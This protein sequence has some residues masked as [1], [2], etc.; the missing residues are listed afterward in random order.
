MSLPRDTDLLPPD[1]RGYE[2][3]AEG[4]INLTQFKPQGPVGAAFLADRDSMIRGIRGPFGSGKTN[5]AFYDCYQWAAASP[6]T[7]RRTSPESGFKPIRMFGALSIRDTY[8]NLET[9]IKSWHAW[10]TR[11]DGDWTGGSGDRPAKHAIAYDLPD[12]TVLEFVHE[13][14]AIGDRTIE[15][16]MLG[17]EFNWIFAN[18]LTTLGID[19]LTYAAGRVGRYPSAKHFEHPDPAVR[20]ARVEQRPAKIIADFNAPEIGTE[21]Y[22]YWEE[23][24][25]ENAKLYVQ[26]G[27]RHP[28]AENL[29]NLPKDYYKN[30]IALNIHKP[31]WIKRFIDNEYGFSRTG[32]PVFMDEFNDERHVPQNDIGI[33][34]LP[35]YIGLD[36][37][38]GLQPAATIKQWSPQG[39]IDLVLS[40][41]LGR[42]GPARFA[43][44]L[45]ALLMQECKGL[46][47]AG[48][49]IDPSAF[50][51]IDH[52]S[53]ELGFCDVVGRAIGA[54]VQQCWTNEL[55]PRLDVWRKVLQR[56][57]GNRPMLQVSKRC[58]A[59]RRG[60]NSVYAY[61]K[62]ADGNLTNDPKP[63]KTGPSGEV[64]HEIDAGGYG[65]C[66][67]LG[68]EF[69]LHDRTPVVRYVDP[70][71]RRASSGGQGR[72]MRTDFDV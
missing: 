41:H 9:L 33:H 5:L 13:F 45:R 50:R 47:I 44:A 11:Q 67:M 4:S 56:N 51:G 57:V 28:L 17:A 25:P 3:A 64:G 46:P 52:E 7:N 40:L 62:D 38:M 49:W 27:G 55:G 8:R 34:D 35:I 58:H 36:G 30:Q 71:R 26:P 22:S 65:L 37:G 72:T 70:S 42:C 53:G 10:A 12:G 68:S 69:V 48:C 16:A 63:S 31:W 66:G 18:E 15:E 61:A 54:P 23:K 2:I 60:L 14:R 32:Q 29:A 20:R 39:W 19:I 59:I 43:E 1:E 6:V 21:V 24:R